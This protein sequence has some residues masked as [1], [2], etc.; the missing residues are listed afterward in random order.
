M[1]A[2]GGEPRSATI[3][4]ILLDGIEKT[5]LPL[6]V[7]DL[8]R[9]FEAQYAFVRSNPRQPNEYY[10]QYA[11]AWIDGKPVILVNGFSYRYFE[12]LNPESREGWRRHF[13]TAS[14]GGDSYWCAIYSTETSGFLPIRIEDGEKH[15]RP[16]TV[17]FNGIA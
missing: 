11:A 12:S 5:L 6:L 7:V 9:I 13:V 10:R 3:P 8:R 1:S 4:P 17:V 14:D 2:C 15:S 16:W